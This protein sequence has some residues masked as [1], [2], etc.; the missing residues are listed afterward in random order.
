[1]FK[2]K[3]QSQERI[4]K[5]FPSDGYPGFCN[6][7]AVS[8]KYGYAFIGTTAGLQVR[9][10][11]SMTDK[12]CAEFKV[13][14]GRVQQLCIATGGDENVL[15]V[16][17]R[18]KV[19][20][21]ARFYDLSDLVANKTSSLPD[22][23]CQASI[24]AE[25]RHISSHPT[26]ADI[27]L[28][29]CGSVLRAYSIERRDFI[30]DTAIE[31]VACFAVCADFIAVASDSGS[32]VNQHDLL[33]GKFAKRLQK[34]PGIKMVRS[35]AFCNGD[36]FATLVDDDNNVDIA[37]VGS[38]TL[39]ENVCFAEGDVETFAFS[40]HLSRWGSVSNLLLTVFTSSS[41]S[42]PTFKSSNDGEW[43]LLEVY[44]NERIE[45][46][47][48]E[49]SEN[50]GVVGMILD[51]ANGKDLPG[52]SPDEPSWPAMPI[53]HLLTYDGQLMSYYV[54]NGDRLAGKYPS[55]TNAKLQIP[56]CV[57]AVDTSVAPKPKAVPPFS[58][59][60]APAKLE[61]KK[62][63]PQSQA[64]QE[65]PF[66]AASFKPTPQTVSTLEKSQI[67]A[68]KPSNVSFGN[69]VDIPVKSNQVSVTSNN[70]PISQL[71]IESKSVST[72][73][74]QKQQIS[75]TEGKSVLLP[76][77][78]AEF[79]NVFNKACF[80]IQTD[81]EEHKKRSIVLFKSIDSFVKNYDSTSLLHDAE[82]EE[83][84]LAKQ[85][86][87]LNEQ[88]ET[89]MDLK[90]ELVSVFARLAEA[91]SY[92][93]SKS[94]QHTSRL[95]LKKLSPE[96]AEQQF[97]IRESLQSKDDILDKI[98]DNI[99]FRKMVLE[100]PS[101]SRSSSLD[102]VYRTM[103]NIN[104]GALNKSTQ[105]DSLIVEVEVM[106][107]KLGVSDRTSADSFAST[108]SVTAAIPKCRV[109]SLCTAKEKT[110]KIRKLFSNLVV[111]HVNKVSAPSYQ[112]VLQSM[113]QNAETKDDVTDIN[114]NEIIPETS[115]SKVSATADISEKHGHIVDKRSE[116]DARIENSPE[117]KPPAHVFGKTFPTLVE[118]PPKTSFAIP[119]NSADVTVSVFS[120]PSPIKVPGIA[121]S[122]PDQEKTT[123][124]LPKFA[125]IS[126]G[127][128]SNV[129]KLVPSSL[130]FSDSKDQNSFESDMNS[131]E[132][133]Q[134]A[135]EKALES[136]QGPES[137]GEGSDQEY[138]E[139][140]AEVE[141][142][143][144]QNEEQEEPEEVIDDSLLVDEGGI[145][146]SDDNA[147]KPEE[148]NNNDQKEETVESKE[149]VAG[150]EED[151]LGSNNSQTAGQE[152]K[153]P[154][155]FGGF[156]LAISEP[157]TETPTDP[158]K[159]DEI[160]S[161]SSSMSLQGLEGLDDMELSQRAVASPVDQPKSPS[162]GSVPASQTMAAAKAPFGFTSQTPITSFAS[163]GKS[164]S[165]GGIF[166]TAPDASKPV[167]GAA[168][169][170][171]QPAAEVK[172]VFGTSNAP[173]FGGSNLS[174]GVTSTGSASNAP[175]FGT[176]SFGGIQN[177][178]APSFGT[179]AFGSSTQPA[180]GSPSFG[181]P[182]KA[183]NAPP[184]F[185]TPA[186]QA[187]SPAAAFGTPSF[188]ASGFGQAPKQ[189][190]FGSSGFGSSAPAFGASGFASPQNAAPS[191]GINVPSNVFG[192]HAA[193]P[194]VTSFG[195]F[196]QSG[197]ATAATSNAQ[198]Q[199][200]GFGFGGTAN[201]ANVFGS[202]N[203]A[204]NA[205]TGF[206]SQAKQ[207][208]SVFGSAGTGNQTPAPSA[209]FTQFR[210]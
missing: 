80:S 120:N 37:V 55:M 13:D 91:E 99:E 148:E 176:G 157:I 126:F 201:T 121:V 23:I 81:I 30:S 198:Q 46:P 163:F 42:F 15:A 167:F 139:S 94:K 147:S 9:R 104:C 164:E 191:T 57:I 145:V 185:G 118:S 210:G 124:E 114:E 208:P 84:K 204:N 63:Q 132:L 142:Y 67:E 173:A 2:F 33:T 16:V 188:G 41:D 86:Q 11:D 178:A 117:I 79:L 22:P 111:S 160:A 53:C 34:I 96:Q 158:T 127:D 28:L 186:T 45:L 177:T 146:Y 17:V 161:S 190:A 202:G 172:S 102:T 128:K 149:L 65:L 113:E 125:A 47:I 116:S 61:E 20:S 130:L 108:K 49:E 6:L 154:L 123:V 141:Q 162:F 71:P 189:T 143:E 206:G 195:A 133:A 112:N 19:R 48:P 40:S 187:A 82:N 182:I 101:K 3:L 153:E 105:I 7:L 175:T 70:G 129:Q 75:A 8:N 76:H 14:D 73:S 4:C 155:N 137:A 207:S 12:P 203:V 193:K 98:F 10:L 95:S 60:T 77:E 92:L 32:A 106:L 110:S 134:D 29:L 5:P 56:K 72:K 21:I 1:M 115:I 38:T 179:T 166:G 59:G 89:I 83:Q 69:K 25:V 24:E 170:T 196:G 171:A 138:T 90:D 100:D 43:D 58:F 44:E 122:V 109:T 144:S 169:T 39:F 74:A 159:A 194:V 93:K 151:K 107:K 199:S 152:P 36:L 51:M 103:R 174:F 52:D 135:I 62:Q 97:R 168:S 119:N 50:A 68:A 85:L 184:A 64:K 136:D 66:G 183:V 156:S 197:F 78:A 200:T 209:N 54:I 35:L 26:L 165:T 88:S 131:L 192:S 205:P 180:F 27:F 87:I 181:T 140:E 18:S 31:D 150:G